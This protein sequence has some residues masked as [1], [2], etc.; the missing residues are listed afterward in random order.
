LRLLSNESS[1][2]TFEYVTTII[3]DD[4]HYVKPLIMLMLFFRT[5]LRATYVDLAGATFWW[6]LRRLF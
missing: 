2:F 4:I 3:I 5:G 6:P 1:Q